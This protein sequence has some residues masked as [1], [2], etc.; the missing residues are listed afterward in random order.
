MGREDAPIDM[1]AVGTINRNKL[2]KLASNFERELG[3]S[4]NYSVMTKGDFKYRY[5]ITDRFLYDLLGGKNMIII[6][7]LLNKLKK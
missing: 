1:L 2:K 3:K 5:S 6:D 4:I 7:S